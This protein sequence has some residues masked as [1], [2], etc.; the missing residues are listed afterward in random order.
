LSDG[1]GLTQL[2]AQAWKLPVIASRYCGEV[3]RDEVNGV[4]LEEVSGASIAEVLSELLREPEKL[5]AMAGRSGVEECFS[6]SRLA[7]SLSKL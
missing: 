1:F 2:E 3:V 7:S 4:V 6:L 5:S